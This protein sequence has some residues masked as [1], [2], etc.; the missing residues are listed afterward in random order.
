M[1]W[2]RGEKE[3]WEDFEVRVGIKWLGGGK[4]EIYKVVLNDILV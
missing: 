1:K 4:K 3:R 2:I